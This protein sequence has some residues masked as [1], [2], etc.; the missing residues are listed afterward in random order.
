MEYGGRTCDSTALFDI[1]YNSNMAPLR[2][3]LTFGLCTE[4]GH[5]PTAYYG[6]IFCEN[7]QIQTWRPCQTFGL[8]ETNLYLSNEFFID[9]IIIIIIIIIMKQK[10][11]YS[12][13]VPLGTHRTSTVQSTVT[14]HR[15]VTDVSKDRSGFMFRVKQSEQN[16]C[17]A[18]Q[19]HRWDN[20]TS[21]ISYQPYTTHAFVSDQLTPVP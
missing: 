15:V 13:R 8:Q 19:Q 21:L 10:P 1:T 9:I 4:E 2:K 3:L 5:R 18:M 16:D 17:L 6:D 12:L 14:S 11:Q 7:Q 20:L